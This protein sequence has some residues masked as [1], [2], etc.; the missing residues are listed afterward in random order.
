M[1]IV[2][3]LLI[4][5]TAVLLSAQN[6]VSNVAKGVPVLKYTTPY[7]WEAYALNGVLIFGVSP[8]Q[9]EAERTIQSFKYRNEG[10]SAEPYHYVIQ[11]AVPER[12]EYFTTFASF[13]PK[14]YRVLSTTEIAALRILKMDGLINAA[15]F[16]D[17]KSS[18]N[19][20]ECME[21]LSNL[22]NNF[23]P[24]RFEE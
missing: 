16:L 14:G 22:H 24:Y 23:K 12:P 10:T 9:E 7:K 20:S 19:Y 11:K 3:L 4:A 17:K 2:T 21:Y 18:K 6:Q 15:V 1:K 5:F 13:C 8:T